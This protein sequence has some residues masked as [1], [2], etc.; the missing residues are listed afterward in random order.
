MRKKLVLTM[1]LLLS[2]VAP[3]AALADSFTISTK[4]LD[5]DLDNKA[6]ISF[7]LDSSQDYYGFQA[8]V[9]LPEGLTAEDVTLNA[10]RTEGGNFEVVLGSAENGALRMAAFS[11][12]KTPI[13][14]GEGEL[15]DLKVILDNFKGG[16]VKVSISNVIFTKEGNVD[17]SLADSDATLGIAVTE[18]CFKR[19]NLSM[20]VGGSTTLTPVFFPEY[21]TDQS[22]T[23]SSSD[24]TIA[25]VDEDGK[26]TAVAEGET[27]ITV[28]SSNE[29]TATIPVKVSTDF[30]A[31]ESVTISAETLEL[32]EGEIEKLTAEV[33]PEDATD[34]AVTWSSSNKAIATV[35]ADGNVKALKV[36]TA[37]ITAATSNNDV[38]ATCTVT[39]SPILAE[40]VTLNKNTAELKVGE[41]VELSATVLPE[42]TS[43]KTVKWTSSDDT[44]ATVVDGV[45]TA[46]AIGEANI[47]ATCACGKES[48]T[49]VVTVV[50]TP[51]TSVSLGEDTL[52]LTEGE[53]ATL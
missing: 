11:A 41:T 46:I 49:C 21:A 9:T 52:S 48:D 13:K 4:N 37:V 15:V 51:V 33:S 38:T 16:D 18:V 24:T 20:K 36:G 8:D 27:V 40:S 31:V 3:L 12:N 2:V 22:V 7:S 47:T 1:L 44:V 50:K 42:N 32:K 26:V 6:T 29:K 19:E 53:N 25:T 14:A 34:T 28:T 30:I 45:V 5:V 17:E 35:D 39:V 23:W 43:D 10:E